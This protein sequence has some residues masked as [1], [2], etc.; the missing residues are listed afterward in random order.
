ML[1]GI[2][3]FQTK[4]PALP[5]GLVLAV[6]YSP[7]FERFVI[8]GFPVRQLWE[9]GDV[10]LNI[11]TQICNMIPIGYPFSEGMSSTAFNDLP[12]NLWNGFLRF[13]WECVPLPLSSYQVLR[14]VSSVHALARHDSAYSAILN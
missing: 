11:K 5:A 6:N 13:L 10:R 4:K 14:G 12:L 9:N 3:S 7:S 1:S 8:F 2:Y